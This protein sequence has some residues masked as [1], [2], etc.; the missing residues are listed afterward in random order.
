M[1]GY[2]H[3]IFINK[4]LLRNGSATAQ[5]KW[6]ETSLA[7]EIENPGLIADVERETMCQPNPKFQFFSSL[8]LLELL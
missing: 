8:S 6:G 7:L 3:E 4:Q 5:R 2:F 1:S